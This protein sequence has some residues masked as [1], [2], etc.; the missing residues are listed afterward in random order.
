MVRAQ[1]FF[2]DIDVMCQEG[3]RTE[4]L[5]PLCSSVS[6]SAGRVSQVVLAHELVPLLDASIAQFVELD[7]CFA[8]VGGLRRSHQHG[9]QE[10]QV[11]KTLTLR[12]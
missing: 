11:V 7:P 12:S 2:A 4:R 9:I 8:L 3:Y 1:R 5:A 6:G 10:Q